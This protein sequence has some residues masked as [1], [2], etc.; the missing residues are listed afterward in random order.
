MGFDRGSRGLTS[1]KL[2]DLDS[3][4][5]KGLR[6][7]TPRR[8]LRR[9]SLNLEPTFDQVPEERKRALGVDPL[10]D[11]DDARA[12]EIVGLQHPASLTN[13][14]RVALCASIGDTPRPNH[15]TEREVTTIT[16]LI[17]Q[18]DA[19]RLHRRPL[20][21]VTPHA[22]RALFPLVR[23]PFRAA[24]IMLNTAGGMLRK[25]LK[26]AN[27]PVDNSR[28]LSS[29]A[30]AMRLR[31]LAPCA[32]GRDHVVAIRKPDCTVQMRDAA[33]LPLG[34][35]MQPDHAG[36]THALNP[37]VSEPMPVVG[38]WRAIP[39]GQGHGHTRT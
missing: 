11:R 18:R 7:F 3:G 21:N 24:L 19:N 27:R 12:L 37:R 35:P 38:R 22:T 33:T 10:R 4:T 39:K 5:P 28:V 17:L 1:R 26:P 34:H 16:V 31:Q 25:V 36:A 15:A 29:L 9:S 20:A 14:K 8:G 2:L 32:D 13:S 6:P 23:N 30:G